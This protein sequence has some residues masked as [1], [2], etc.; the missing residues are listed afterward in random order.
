M[1]KQILNILYILPI[2]IF[3]FLIISFYLR[4]IASPGDC[5]RIY[6]PLLDITNSFGCRYQEQIENIFFWSVLLSVFFSI[7]WLFEKIIKTKPFYFFKLF[8]YYAGFALLDVQSSF[9]RSLDSGNVH[10]FHLGLSPIIIIFFGYLVIKQTNITIKKFDLTYG[11]IFNQLFYIPKVFPIKEFLN[12][13]KFSVTKPLKKINFIQILKIIYVIIFTFF[14]TSL[15]VISLDQSLDKG[16]YYNLAFI[17]YYFL[18]P[19]TIAPY[20]IYRIYNYLKKRK[21]QKD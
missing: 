6:E 12:I 13:Y 17:F 15:S 11:K 20:Q 16:I 1:K 2:L 19:Y 8:T 9:W 10:W 5:Y 21:N 18:I 7:P 3:I 14:L 4:L